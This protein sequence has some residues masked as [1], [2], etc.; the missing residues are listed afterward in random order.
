VSFVKYSDLG[1]SDNEEAG[2]TI[3]FCPEA[4]TPLLMQTDLDGGVASGV[5]GLCPLGSERPLLRT[6]S[7]FYA[8]SWSA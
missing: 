8:S 3:K 2:S 7:A 1:V 6:F 4:G 5:G